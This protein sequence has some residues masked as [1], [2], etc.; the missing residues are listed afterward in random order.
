M[1]PAGPLPGGP[2]PSYFSQDP[3]LPEAHFSAQAHSP[4]L[5]SPIT[6]SSMPRLALTGRGQHSQRESPCHRLHPGI[7]WEL[8]SAPSLDSHL[9]VR[10]GRDPFLEEATDHKGPGEC[11]RWPLGTGLRTGVPALSGAGEVLGNRFHYADHL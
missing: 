10:E 5:L 7:R 11:G 9:R 8:P 1:L 2:P 6:P 4:V 3:L